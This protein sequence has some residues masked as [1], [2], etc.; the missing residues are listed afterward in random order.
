MSIEAGKPLSHFKDALNFSKRAVKPVLYTAGTFGIMGGVGFLSAHLKENKEVGDSI[1]AHVRETYPRKV[2][3]EEYEI[4]QLATYISNNRDSNID[5]E[6]LIINIPQHIER[7]NQQIEQENTRSQDASKL[8]DQLRDEHKA[9]VGPRIPID[10]T[11]I[12]LSFAAF[13]APS[14]S[15]KMINKFK[16]K[17]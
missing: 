10:I 15:K 9:K 16:R 1:D 17:G 5:P 4:A 14:V 12:L 13:L 8:R 3:G 11:V 2:S 7:Y 6:T